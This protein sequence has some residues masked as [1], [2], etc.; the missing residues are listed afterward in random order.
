MPMPMLMLIYLFFK[1]TSDTF[2]RPFQLHQTKHAN[3]RVVSTPEVSAAT[4][5]AISSVFFIEPHSLH[6]NM[7]IKRRLKFCG[8]AVCFVLM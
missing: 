3:Q 4:G 7:K 1:I 2:P 8:G 5:S 6:Q